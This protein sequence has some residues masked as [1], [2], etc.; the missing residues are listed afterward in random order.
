MGGGFP[1]LPLDN[2]FLPE[3]ATSCMFPLLTISTFLRFTL[4]QLV[5]LYFCGITYILVW[6]GSKFAKLL[7]GCG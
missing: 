4:A 2:I 5:Y 3:F 7:V 6:N 1:L